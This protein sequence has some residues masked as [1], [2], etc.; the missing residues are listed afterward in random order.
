MA[1]GFSTLGPV[2]TDVT[3]NLIQALSRPV[4][5]MVGLS[6]EMMARERQIDTQRINALGNLA[7]RVLQARE[8]QV[9]E[10][11]RI[12]RLGMQEKRQ[13]LLNQLTEQNII[14]VEQSNR[15]KKMNIAFR[16]ETDP[17]KAKQLETSMNREALGL[18]RDRI[19]RGKAELDLKMQKARSETE[20]A[21]LRNRLTQ[22]QFLEDNVLQVLGIEAGKLKA[23]EALIGR[24]LGGGVTPATQEEIDRRQALASQGLLYKPESPRTQEQEERQK[25]ATEI[26]RVRLEQM[27]QPRTMESEERE[28]IALETARL[29]LEKL[30]QPDKQEP[31][32]TLTKMSDVNRLL[33]DKDDAWKEPTNRARIAQSDSSVIVQEEAGTLFGT[34][35]KQRPVEVYTSSS[36][37]I[38][39]VAKHVARDAEIFQTDPG[40]I[41]Q[42]IQE[43]NE[44]FADR[45]DF[46][47]YLKKTNAGPVLREVN[48]FSTLLKSAGVD[49]KWAK[50]A[51]RSLQQEAQER[52]EKGNTPEM[53]PE[54]ALI[55]ILNQR[56]KGQ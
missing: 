6:P 15:L 39:R 7:S 22:A 5:S 24:A 37:W 45:K 13:T 11:D 33:K 56:S 43:A 3:R 4:G 34:N 10:E 42:A 21:E 53:T 9:A 32:I 25:I 55:V 54:E 38:P 1:N 23:Q 40:V 19:A 29:K 48:N 18:L 26:A 28:R 52:F 51:L 14:G 35:L 49:S 50:K 30:R 31:L 27:K 16:Q 2:Q 36:V 44:N 12:R 46:F 8:S 17:L 47:W 41:N 20:R